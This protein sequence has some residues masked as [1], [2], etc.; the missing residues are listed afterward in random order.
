[1]P[2][3]S[4]SPDGP[5]DVEPGPFH[6]RCRPAVAAA[7]P[8]RLGQLHD[9]EVDLAGEGLGPL[10]VTGLEGVLA[11]AAQLLDAVPVRGAGGAVEHRPGVAQRAAI[12][13]V[14]SHALDAIHQVERVALLSGVGH[15]LREVAQALGVHDAAR[16]K[17][18]AW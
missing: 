17:S 13:P 16:S 5:G 11:L 10:L 15:E 2:S 14:S 8:E 3:S 7:Q 18:T 1:M 12:R 4:T 6:G 9:Q